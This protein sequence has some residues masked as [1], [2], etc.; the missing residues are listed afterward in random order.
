VSDEPDSVVLRY[1]RRIDEKLDRVIDDVRDLKVRATSI[2][3]GLVGVHRRL[4]G[5]EK[6]LELTAA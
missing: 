5:I 3:A 2:E 1:L 4:D 6:R